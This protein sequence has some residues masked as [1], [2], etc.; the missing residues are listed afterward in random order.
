MAGDGNFKW[1]WG[2]GEYP[3][4]YNGPFDSREEAIADARDND[5]H[6]D[7]GFTICEADK[8]AP[9][10][11]DGYRFL[12]EWGDLNSDLANPSGEHFGSDVCPSKEQ[13]DELTDMLKQAFTAWMDRHKLHPLVW[14]FATM[15]NEQVFPAVEAGDDDT[16]D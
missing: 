16:N 5:V 9:R 10:Y 1:W 11:I 3:E 13:L 14:T 8:E 7:T 15:R 12:E 2:E 4:E 6:I